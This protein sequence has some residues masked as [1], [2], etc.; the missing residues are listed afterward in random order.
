LWSPDST[1]ELKDLKP[2]QIIDELEQL[3]VSS[4]QRH[5]IADAPVGVLC[6]GGVD[7]SLI[8]AIA[9]KTHRNLAVF[10]ANVVGP[11]SEYDAAYRF[12]TYLGLDLRSV[13]VLD[14]DFIDTIADITEHW[15]HPFFAC[16]HS[17]PYL[18]V[19]RLVRSE[20]VKAV[21][22]GEG[23]DEG[24]LGYSWMAPTISGHIRRI[25]RKPFGVLK[26]RNVATHNS[27][28]PLHRLVVA[29]QNRFELEIEEQEIRTKLNGYDKE[30]KARI[31][32]NVRVFGYNLRPIL[33]RNDSMGMAASIEARYPYLTLEVMKFAVNLPYKW[34]MKFSPTS[35]DKNHYS[36]IDK[37]VLRKL[38]ERYLPK[39]LPYRFKQPFPVDAF[40]RMQISTSYLEK[41]FI[42][43]LLGL[44]S[45]EAQYLVENSD[46]VLKV[47]I[48][49]ADVWASLFLKG[50]KK[51]RVSETLSSHITIRPN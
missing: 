35:L 37:W 23:A 1:T 17:V 22:S 34:K 44:S 39:D 24:F 48:M 49:Q 14:R 20:S 7:S 31:I 40:S 5:L 41:S 6:S 4:V 50:I 27:K 38:A 3:L 36:Y 29:L 33:H 2:V 9:A 45:K 15:G 12:A 32:E 30:D 46:Q 42:S 43:E 8:L 25:L 13:D 11:L 26:L 18:M 19:S 16:P 47:K 28:M 21:L 10:H 51:D